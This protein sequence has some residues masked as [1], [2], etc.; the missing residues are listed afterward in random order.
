MYI[1]KNISFSVQN[2]MVRSQRDG[3][4]QIYGE[5]YEFNTSIPILYYKIYG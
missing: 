2:E 5:S 4:L 1:E 3:V